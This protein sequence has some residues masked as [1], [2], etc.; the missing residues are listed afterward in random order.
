MIVL[1]SYLDWELINLRQTNL[2]KYYSQ[3]YNGWNYVYVR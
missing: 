2:K 1:I 3:I